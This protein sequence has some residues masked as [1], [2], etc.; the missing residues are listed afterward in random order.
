MLLAFCALSAAGGSIGLIYNGLGMSVQNLRHTVFHSYVVPGIILA[1]IVGSTQAAAAVLLKIS[2][3]LTLVAVAV[4]GFGLC[5]WIYGE[6]YLT[7]II[8]WLQTVYFGLGIA[9]LILAFL[10]LGLL[11]PKSGQGKH[12]A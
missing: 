8:S 3:K 11:K 5:I 9:E 6:I 1:L 7:Q 10:L 12:A 4:A 2:H